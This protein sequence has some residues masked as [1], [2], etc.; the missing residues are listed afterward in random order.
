MCDED[1]EVHAACCVCGGGMEELLGG[2][3]Q[4]KKTSAQPIKTSFMCDWGRASDSTL[5]RPTDRLSAFSAPAG[6]ER[7]KLWPAFRVPVL[8]SGMIPARLR[9]TGLHCYFRTRHAIQMSLNMLGGESEGNA[10][11]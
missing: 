2:K 5:S 3:K 10:I 11:L 8:L 4:N 1:R 6:S 7:L 9:S